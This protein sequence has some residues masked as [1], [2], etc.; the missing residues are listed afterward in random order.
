MEI[1]TWN[2]MDIG[3]S[4][5]YMGLVYLIHAVIVMVGVT[6]KWRDR[7]SVLKAN[8]VQSYVMD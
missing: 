6:N 5:M 8:L 3:W 1:A 2:L 4:G 7:F